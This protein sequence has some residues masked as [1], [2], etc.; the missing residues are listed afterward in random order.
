MPDKT[1]EKSPNSSGS[2]K[3]SNSTQ[4]KE[5]SPS[6]ALKAEYNPDKP[7]KLT[8]KR[9][10]SATEPDI[11]TSPDRPT[12]KPRAMNEEQ[13][14]NLFD[15]LRNKSDLDFKKFQENFTTEQTRINSVVTDQLEGIKTQIT[16]FQVLRRLL[17]RS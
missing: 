17:S 3:S 4:T 9:L 13:V 8:L 11:D 10:H 5:S 12:K 15:K 2:N 14:E 16:K 1:P 7:L 6:T